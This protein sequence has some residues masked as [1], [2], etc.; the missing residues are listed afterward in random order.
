MG[1]SVCLPN[2]PRPGRLPIDMLRE[3]RATMHLKAFDANSPLVRPEKRGIAPAVR[4]VDRLLEQ[5]SLGLLEE[6]AGRP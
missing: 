6:L 4:Q 5:M 1:P 3:G 2:H